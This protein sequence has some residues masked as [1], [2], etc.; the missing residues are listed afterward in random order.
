MFH[1]TTE[2]AKPGEERHYHTPAKWEDGLKCPKHLEDPL[3]DEYTLDE[4]TQLDKA[5]MSDIT[6]E[7]I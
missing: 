5:T 6:R 2:V 1:D 3:A 4:K 7:I